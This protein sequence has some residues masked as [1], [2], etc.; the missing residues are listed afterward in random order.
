MKA[1][2]LKSKRRDSLEY[3]RDYAEEYL[4]G[5]HGV[6]D[7]LITTRKVREINGN[8]S[9]NKIKRLKFNDLALDLYYWELCRKFSG[10]DYK[11]MDEYISN[12]FYNKNDKGEVVSI[13]D[14]VDISYSP[15]EVLS[16]VKA[17]LRGSVQNQVDMNKEE[18]YDLITTDSFSNPNFYTRGLDDAP[19]DEMLDRSDVVAMDEYT[20]VDD[21]LEPYQEFIEY[22]GGNIRNLLSKAQIK[23]YDLM[24]NGNMTTDDVLVQSGSLTQKDMAIKLGITQQAVSDMQ[25]AIK[26]RIVKS[27]TEF[28]ILK[29]VVS[30]RDTYRTINGFL[31]HFEQITTYD[32]TDSF[33]YFGYIVQFLKTNYIDD[34]ELVDVT[35]LLTNKY[36]YSN[37]ILDV[38]TDYV[39]ASTYR[40]VEL[41]VFSTDT[42]VK[43]TQRKKDS[44]VMNII[45]AFKKYIKDVNSSIYGL[46]ERIEKESDNQKYIDL[47]S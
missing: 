39:N 36:D 25:K 33:D 47:L 44:F 12:A 32:T 35:K 26:A 29:K 13:F 20:R 4:K 45:K 28:T 18:Y 9:E 17:S 14:N 5:N 24:P 43:L 22:N 38:V 2:K 10:L 40:V 8:G 11:D 37:S 27:Y 6:L 34:E 31:Q 16:F 3:L 21:V 1:F 23:L 42:N 7:E 41:E 15:L 46:S 30:D 19:E